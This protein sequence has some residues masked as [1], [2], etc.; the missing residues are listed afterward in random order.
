MLKKRWGLIDSRTRFLGKT[1]KYFGAGFPFNGL[2]YGHGAD[3]FLILLA[4]TEGRSFNICCN[5]EK[6]GYQS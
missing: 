4:I 6:L 1:P 2:F 5:K 3:V